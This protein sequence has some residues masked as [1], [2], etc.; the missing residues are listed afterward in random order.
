MEKQTKDDLSNSNWSEW[1]TSPRIIKRA[2][3]IESITNFEIKICFVNFFWAKKWVVLSISFDKMKEI[4]RSHYNECNRCVTGEG[5]QSTLSDL[6]FIKGAIL[7]TCAWTPMWAW[8]DY[9]DYY[10][11]FFATWLWNVLVFLFHY[12][13]A[14]A[15][16]YFCNSV[17]WQIEFL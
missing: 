14:Q 3:L 9:T 4:L 6:K 13:L 8:C 10:F 17:T 2:I 12:L 11:T 1:S 16:L 15:Y 7:D 5:I